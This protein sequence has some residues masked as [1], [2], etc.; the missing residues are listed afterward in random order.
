MKRDA[1]YNRFECLLSER[2]KSFSGSVEDK[3]T[4]WCFGILSRHTSYAGI[5]DLRSCARSRA[6]LLIEKIRKWIE[7]Q[8]SHKH[9]LFPSHLEVKIEGERIL[10]GDWQLG[11]IG[12]DAVTGMSKT[13]DC[14]SSRKINPTYIS[15]YLY[16]SWPVLCKIVSTGALKLSI[17]REC[18]DLYEFLPAWRNQEEKDKLFDIVNNSQQVIMCFSRTPSS[19][20]MWAH[21]G[22]YGRGAVLRFNVP[23]YRCI[24][25]ESESECLLVVAESE[26]ELNVDAE[27]YVSISQITY[28]D[29]RPIYK[30]CKT[31][32]EYSRFAAQKGRAWSYEE[33]MRIVF[34][35][36]E[37]RTFIKDGKYFTPIMMPYLTE[38]ILG[39]RNSCTIKD[40]KLVLKQIL[41][42]AGN[43]QKLRFSISKAK[44]DSSSYIVEIP[45]NRRNDIQDI[46]DVPLYRRLGLGVS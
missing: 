32:Y 42:D 21:Y 24:A 5:A 4:A 7:V 6:C 44:Y 1:L 14:R 19:P 28:S 31:F 2:L 17:P 13:E 43:N 3:I 46:S 16:V 12:V 36:D 39:A 9:L 8:G 11:Y 23:V 41:K 34:N 27:C 40:A 20:V 45:G 37:N 30:S 35:Y 38:I 22:D 26:T 15:L 25:G 18:N 10:V 29:N 33:E